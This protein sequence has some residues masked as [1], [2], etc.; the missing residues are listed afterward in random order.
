MS[1]YEACSKV[2]TALGSLTS[3]QTPDSVRVVPPGH[4]DDRHAARGATLWINVEPVG[5]SHE[6]ETS[7]SYLSTYEMRFSAWW[8]KPATSLTTTA[9][10][11]GTLGAACLAQLAHNDLGGWARY[12]IPYN[13]LKLTYETVG[14]ADLAY[15]VRGDVVVHRQQ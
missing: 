2:A 1:I 11:L 10:A 12:G 9:Q 8:A 13:E 14:E 4:G 6:D 15:V 3:P 5:E 7:S